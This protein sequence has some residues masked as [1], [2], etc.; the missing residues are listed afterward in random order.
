MKGMPTKYEGELYFAPTIFITETN[1]KKIATAQKDPR[2]KTR[3]GVNDDLVGQ[4]VLAS[5]ILI[6]ACDL[7]SAECA[8]DRLEAFDSDDLEL[9]ESLANQRMF[10]TS[11]EEWFTMVDDVNSVELKMGDSARIARAFKAVN[12]LQ[13]EELASFFE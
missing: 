7:I 10:P 6:R 9:H 4:I 12:R 3:K 13:D 8:E 2:A 11:T 5:C 1:S